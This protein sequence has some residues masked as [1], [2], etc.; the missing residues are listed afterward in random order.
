MHTTFEHRQR[1]FGLVES[2]V[3]LVVVSVGMIG[4]AVLYGQGLSASRTALNRTQAVN[5]AADMADRVR[6]NRRGGASYGGA[7]ADNNCEAGGGTDCTTAQLAAHDVWEWQAQV[8]ALLPGG[9]GTVVYTGTTPPTYTIRVGWQEPVGGAQNV[10]IAV[11]VPA[12]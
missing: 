4:I 9:A 1:G 12:L 5:L 7:G 11:R 2:L 6:T 8:N 3:A 10:Q